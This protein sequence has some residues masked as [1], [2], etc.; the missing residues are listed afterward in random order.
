MSQSHS[1]YRY[2]LL[3]LLTV[4]LVFSLA[5][6]D[7]SG[8]S[9]E[10]ATI[11][12]AQVQQRREQIDQI[13][14]KLRPHGL[15]YDL[16]KTVKVSGNSVTLKLLA[17]DRDAA[18]LEFAGDQPPRFM[19]DLLSG[20]DPAQFTG[21]HPVAGP[22]LVFT[23]F[24]SSPA[25]SATMLTLQV[26]TVNGEPTSAGRVEVP[27]DLS[28]IEQLPVSQQPPGSVTNNGMQLEV[29]QYRSGF[30]VTSVELRGTIVSN[31]DLYLVPRPGFGSPAATGGSAIASTGI[32]S[33]GV[34]S[35]TSPPTYFG[36]SAGQ[37]DAD[38]WHAMVQLLDVP[39]SGNLQFRLDWI[40]LKGLKSAGDQQ[41]AKGPWSLT[42]KIPQSQ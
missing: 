23:E 14:A 26:R 4:M 32:W 5:A 17:I 24:N 36:M 11:S 33:L 13:V 12:S 15:V 34:S 16:N 19:F 35:S 3:P 1:H 10:S 28:A 9:N 6:C 30:A 42:V 21:P 37:F 7:T 40:S 2:R 41:V 25:P 20:S 22:A 8:S 38:G 27:V 39:A 29:S 18:F 31:K